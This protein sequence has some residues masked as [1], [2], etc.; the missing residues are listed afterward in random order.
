MVIYRDR[1]IIPPQTAPPPR[2]NS[3]WSCQCCDFPGHTCGDF[4]TGFYRLK[5]DQMVMALW[6]SKGQTKGQQQF[7]PASFRNIPCFS[8]NKY[9]VFACVQ[10]SENLGVGKAW[11]VLFGAS[12]LPARTTLNVHSGDFYSGGNQCNCC[13]IIINTTA[14][15]LVLSRFPLT[16]RRNLELALYQ[17]DNKKRGG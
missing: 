7:C 15:S 4:I 12:W 14:C 8:E 2:G 9:K 6:S 16:M 11:G 10:S 1:N 3:P 17:L 5:R 13:F